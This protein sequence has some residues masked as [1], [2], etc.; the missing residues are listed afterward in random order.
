ASRHPA[1]FYTLSLFLFALALMSKPMVV[2]LPFVLLLLDFWPLQRFQISDFKSQLG[3]VRCLI[4]EKIPFFMLTAAASI[5]AFLAQRAGAAV[6]SLDGIPISARLATALVAYVR[7][8]LKTVWP[9]DLAVFYPYQ[10][11]IPLLISIGAAVLLAAWTVIF[12]HRVGSQPYLL[13]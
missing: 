13:M 6:A 4:C 7:Y 12:V 8:L 5:V 3:V 11:H 10:D 1:R 9:A 2:T